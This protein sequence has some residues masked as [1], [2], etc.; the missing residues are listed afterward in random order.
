MEK[1]YGYIRSY[2]IRGGKISYAQKRSYEKLFPVFGIM[3][4]DPV[5]I[6]SLFGN[7]NPL[8]VEI[9]FGMGRATI[10][11]AEKNPGIN[12]IGIEVHKPGIGRLLWDIER[13]GLNNIRIAE[14][15][16]KLFISERIMN[17]TVSAFHI[18][19]PD[20][21]PKKKHN[22]RRLLARPFTDLLSGKLLSGG[23]IY[24]ISDWQ[25]YAEEALK[26]L[27]ETP[28]LKNKFKGYA[29]K[30]EWRP[31]TEFEKKGINKNHEIFEMIFTG[32]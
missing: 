12:Y 3:N 16:A 32:E 13:L 28:G 23:Y 21:W 27:T 15:D 6:A 4:N 26:A 22:K 17:K 20:P 1:N 9:G 18:F 11:I 8:V 24:V 25:D 5:N 19:F 2:V 31:I 29:D 10:K 30:Q 14:E 7:E